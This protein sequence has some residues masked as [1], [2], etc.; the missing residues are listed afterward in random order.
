MSFGGSWHVQSVQW[1]DNQPG[2]EFKLRHKANAGLKGI[3]DR[4]YDSSSVLLAELLSMRD[5]SWPA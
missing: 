2:R 5:N 3:S 1:S 4:L